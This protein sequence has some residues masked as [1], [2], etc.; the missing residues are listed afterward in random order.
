MGLNKAS[1]PN[2]SFLC[3]LEVAQIYLPGWGGSHSDYKTNL[4]SQLNLHWTG[5]LELS[6][7]IQPQ[8]TRKGKEKIKKFP[9]QIEILLRSTVLREKPPSL[10]NDDFGFRFV[11]LLLP[12]LFFS[13]E[14]KHSHLS[15][16]CMQEQNNGEGDK[17]RLN[18]EPW[19]E[20]IP[21]LPKARTSLFE[22]I[23]P[24][25]RPYC[26]PTAPG[27][28]RPPFRGP[29]PQTSASGL[30]HCSDTVA[31]FEAFPRIQ[32]FSK[33]SSEWCLCTRRDVGS[34]FPIRSC[35]SHGPKLSRLKKTLG[36][37][38]PHPCNRAT[39]PSTDNPRS[40]HG[41]WKSR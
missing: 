16:C 10:F 19:Q 32:L 33:M 7:A 1:I 14:K 39:Y 40:W 13:L 36:T 5:Q 2:F 9:P 22:P 20:D 6:L 30:D 12:F 37:K 29:S 11:N 26:H 35:R 15:L 23:R 21:P 34:L 31:M 17:M 3:S 18:F 28:W 41:T 38:E 24:T 4:S 27:S 25:L 8:N